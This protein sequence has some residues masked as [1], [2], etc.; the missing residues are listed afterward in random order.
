MADEP[1]EKIDWQNGV[2]I[3]FSAAPVA[4]LTIAGAISLGRGLWG[5]FDLKQA[6]FGASL[7]VVAALVELFVWFVKRRSG[8]REVERAYSLRWQALQKC[9]DVLRLIQT[10]PENTTL[11]EV[12]KLLEGYKAAAQ[13]P[14]P[15]E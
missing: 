15:V 9:D 8:E 6:V 7:L 2:Y 3:L 10:P 4:I 13:Q 14:K 5:T 11:V 12:M 1:A